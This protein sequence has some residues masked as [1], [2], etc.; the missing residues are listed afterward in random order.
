MA[1]FLGGNVTPFILSQVL[2]S[3]AILF[4]FAS[5]QFKDRQ[6]IV[7]CL[8]FSAALISSHFM[9]LEQWTAAALMSVA[10]VRYLVSA[11]ST[12]PKLKYTFCT[13][14]IVTSI[15]TFSGLVSVVSCLGTLFQTV[16]AFN[17]DDR[18]LRQL[19][20][21]GTSLW[22]LNNYLVGSPVAVIMEALFIA[23]NLVGYYRYYG[24][25]Y[26]RKI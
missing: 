26:Q 25:N 23:S 21:V 20:I 9:L 2:V 5:F 11:F 1:L 13:V 19:M 8:F 22:L 3:V 7:T 15:V 12:S 6:K 17:K 14:S 10:S 4:D 18:L 24:K 16:A